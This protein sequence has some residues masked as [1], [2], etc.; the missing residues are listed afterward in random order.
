MIRDTISNFRRKLQGKMFSYARVFEAN[1]PHTHEV[2]KDLASFCR[3]HTP[4]FHPDPRIHAMLE[5]RREV[6]LRIQENL[7]LDLE[8]I[9]SLHK[10]KEI[11]PQKELSDGGQARR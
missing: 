3:A 8:E 2:L 9:Y 1:S 4:T 5:G 11:E 7:Q 10:I 6:W